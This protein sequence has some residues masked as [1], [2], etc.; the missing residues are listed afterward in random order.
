MSST[1]GNH[2]PTGKKHSHMCFYASC[3]VVWSHTGDAA[4][5]HCPVCERRSELTVMGLDDTPEQ[6]I[7]Q[8]RAAFLLAVANREVGTSTSPAYQRRWHAA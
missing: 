5:H 8:K 1:C 2:A 6:V 7:K 4:G 3:R